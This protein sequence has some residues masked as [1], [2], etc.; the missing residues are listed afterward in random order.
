MAHVKKFKGT[1]SGSAC[2]SVFRGS[3]F[4]SNVSSTRGSRERTT[5]NILMWKNLFKKGGDARNSRINNR[6]VVKGRA[7][8]DAYPEGIEGTD[9]GI[10]DIVQPTDGTW[11]ITAPKVD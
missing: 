8:I 6:L 11:G 5:N 7:S 4:N 2:N 10:F 3:G 9:K 1:V